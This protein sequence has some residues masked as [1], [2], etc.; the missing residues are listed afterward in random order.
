ME[1]QFFKPKTRSGL[2]HFSSKS[3]RVVCVSVKPF[4]IARL[5]ESQV[6]S[7]VE[8][9]KIPTLG[10]YCC[11]VHCQEGE[12]ANKLTVAHNLTRPMYLFFKL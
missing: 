4:Y 6:L 1:K 11:S 2:K 9:R 10:S 7:G 3:F 5:L 8:I 12:K